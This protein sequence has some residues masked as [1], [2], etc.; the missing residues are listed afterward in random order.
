[1]VAKGFSWSLLRWDDPT[2]ILLDSSADLWFISLP[3]R[4]FGVPVL[5]VD[6]LDIHAG[7]PFWNGLL[8]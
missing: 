8:Q 5:V 6:Q 1:M 7:F 2:W 4:S 3:C